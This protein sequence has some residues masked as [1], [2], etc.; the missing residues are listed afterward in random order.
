[1]GAWEGRGSMKNAACESFAGPTTDTVRSTKARST[2]CALT[3][4]GRHGPGAAQARGEW[5]GMCE[6]AS[7]LGASLP[8]P[9][10]G[11]GPA[12]VSDVGMGVYPISLPPTSLLHLLR[13]RRHCPWRWQ[14][15][16]CRQR[17]N[18]SARPTPTTWT[19]RSAPAS[20]PSP[21]THTP[22]APPPP[23]PPHII[24]HTR[25]ACIPLPTPSKRTHSPSHRLHPTHTCAPQPA[26]RAADP[27]QSPA[28][29]APTPP[30]S[31]DPAI[32]HPRAPASPSKAPGPLPK[33]PAG[34]AGAPG[35]S[36]AP[37]AHVH[38]GLNNAVRLGSPAHGG[39]HTD[40]ER[41]AACGADLIEELHLHIHFRS[42][43][44]RLRPR[45]A[46]A[47]SESATKT[48]AAGPVDPLLPAQP[49]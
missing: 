47:M 8:A 45:P 19:S 46:G 7:E 29:H 16:C 17:T 41:E 4:T 13:R 44:S 18:Q 42:R 40:E 2:V 26:R 14:A 28:T 38:R 35:A 5:R 39:T 24:T 23:P 48:M 36:C 1:M 25:P 6:R 32:P 27:G 20:A 37:C 11:Q 31:T 49:Q 22:P 9:V 10:C 33:L 15:F 34:P 30:G 12:R 3:R 43:R 21:P